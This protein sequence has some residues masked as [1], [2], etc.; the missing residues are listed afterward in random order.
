MFFFHVPWIPRVV[1]HMKWLLDFFLFFFLVY[2]MLVQGRLAS[3]MDTTKG[4]LWS[5]CRF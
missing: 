1:G 5:N 4:A 2:K 3:Y